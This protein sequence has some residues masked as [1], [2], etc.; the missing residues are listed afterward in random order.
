MADTWQTH[1][2][3]MADPWPMADLFG[4]VVAGAVAPFS[5]GGGRGVLGWGFLILLQPTFTGD[6]FLILL[7]APHAQ[8]VGAFGLG[9]GQSD[10]SDKQRKF[11]PLG[12]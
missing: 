9:P 2:R 12:L 11:G 3:P 6:A 7:R 10:K 1:G 5:F 8:A 4:V